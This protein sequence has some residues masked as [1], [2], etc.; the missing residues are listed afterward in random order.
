MSPTPYAPQDIRFLARHEWTH[1]PT[2]VKSDSPL[3]VMYLAGPEV[4]QIN[5]TVIRRLRL[6]TWLRLST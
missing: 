4:S 5:H 1:V 6:S 2:A 3:A